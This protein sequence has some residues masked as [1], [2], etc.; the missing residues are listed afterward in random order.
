MTI[1]FV[2]GVN[3]LSKIG[4]TLDEKGRFGYVIDG[5][6][7]VNYRL[8]LRKGVASELLLFG[9]AV[10]QCGIELANPPSLIFNQIA[11]ADTHRG[12]LE[13]CIE[14][15]EQVNATVINHPRQ[16]LETSRDQV[17]QKLQGIPGVIMPTTQRFQPR[18][19][20]DVFSRAVAEGFGFPFIVRVAGLH[21]GKGMV[22][23][24]SDH[25]RAALHA[26]PFD[27][28]DFYLIEYVSCQDDQG[29][30]HKQRIAVVDGEP[31]LRHALYDGVWNIHSGA[32]NFMMARE[33][34]KEEFVYFDHYAEEMLPPL[35]PV[36]DDITT[37]LKLEY[38]GID[39]SM[40]PDGRMVVFEV[41]ANM[42]FL[43]NPYEVIQYRVDAVIELIYRML[44][45]Y[46]GKRVI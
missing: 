28:R 14:L 31:V 13:R 29:L 45:R 38:Y 2:S 11:D 26:L 42:N 46:S 10:K 24:D 44:T 20:D 3:D 19:P 27:G 6:C 36:I 5:N 30:Y 41:N 22:K 7:S 39:C 12:S 21:A 34:W 16:V 17:S 32:R 35:R 8:P 23:V 43:H 4:V 40:L 18:A 25:D 15:C 33:S 1:L 9:K 37:R